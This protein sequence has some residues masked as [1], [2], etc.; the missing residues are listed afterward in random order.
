MQGINEKLNRWYIHLRN[1][2]WQGFLLKHKA[3]VSVALW[4]F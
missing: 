2:D 4:P 1:F 3:V